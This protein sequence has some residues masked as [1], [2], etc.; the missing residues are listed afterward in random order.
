MEGR[1]AAERQEG[2]IDI[3]NSRYHCRSGRSPKPATSGERSPQ[4]RS[5]CSSGRTPCQNILARYPS[6]SPTWDRSPIRRRRIKGQA[7][8]HRRD[9]AGQ[10]IG[11]S[12]GTAPAKPSTVIDRRARRRFPVRLYIPSDSTPP[13]VSPTTPAK[14]RQSEDRRI[15]D[16]EVIA[17]LE[18]QRQPIEIQPQAPAVAKIGQGDGPH[19]SH[20]KPTGF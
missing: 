7:D 11:M 5:P 4:R 2:P 13:R 3:R 12:D 17:V 1:H 8:G 20:Q 10:K 19:A 14:K 16:V 9:V 15:L 6:G 18:E